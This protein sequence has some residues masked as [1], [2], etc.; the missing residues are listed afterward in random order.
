MPESGISIGHLLQAWG[1]ILA[2]R[3]PN[4][5][6]E[7]TKECPLTCPGCYAY[8]DEHLGGDITLRGLSDFKGD[9]LVDR[10]KAL[11]E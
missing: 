9:E 1:R 3:Q 8:G 11:V 10:F 4:L 7:L 2:G 5:S 6:V